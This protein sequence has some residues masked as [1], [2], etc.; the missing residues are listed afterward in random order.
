MNINKDEFLLMPEEMRLAYVYSRY[1]VYFERLA[2]GETSK[3]CFGL[4]VEDYFKE[5]LAKLGIEVENY[6]SGME[7]AVFTRVKEAEEMFLD[8]E[9]LRKHINNIDE[10]KRE[11][12]ARCLG[13]TVN[14][15]FP[16]F[17]KVLRTSSYD[18]NFYNLDLLT[19]SEKR[20][21]LDAQLECVDLNK[22]DIYKLGLK[23]I[24]AYIKHIY[25]N[26]QRGL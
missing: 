8:F 21:L 1:Y 11:I 20:R 12:F 10:I 13:D 15:P 25:T 19:L 26:N 5:S 16:D 22:T 14:S 9:S 6:V 17:Y 4:F 2:V 24:Q 18:P 23:N 7:Y 3:N